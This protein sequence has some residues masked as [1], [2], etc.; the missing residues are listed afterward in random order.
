MNI[1]LPD[2]DKYIVELVDLHSLA[3]L[4]LVNKFFYKV[5]FAKPIMNQWKHINN[6]NLDT[7][8]DILIETCEM[9]FLEYAH[10]LMNAKV[11][12]K[13]NLIFICMVIMHSD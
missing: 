2:I 13:V 4:M 3:N 6:M 12:M 5:I 9:G 1:I 10:Y 11:K 8:G 7:I